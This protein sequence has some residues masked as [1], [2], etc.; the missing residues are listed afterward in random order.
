MDITGNIDMEIELTLQSV[1]PICF[2]YCTPRL[3]TR[4]YRISKQGL[5]TC[6]FILFFSFLRATK[7]NNKTQEN[8]ANFTKENKYP[9]K[10]NEIVVAE[11]IWKQSH[12]ER[13]ERNKLK[14]RSRV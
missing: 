2:P 5:F 11:I 1:C 8:N 6:A 12:W 4:V 13:I 9:T 3:G 7:T 10:C 14:D